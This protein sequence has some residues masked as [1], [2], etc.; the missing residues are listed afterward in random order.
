[1][2][3]HLEKAVA[4]YGENEILRGTSI[5]VDLG[6]LVSLIGP[7]GAG[8]TTIFRTVSGILRLKQGRK[9]FNG[10]DI[11]NFPAHEISKLGVAQVPEGRIVF[12]SLTV[13]QNILLG[14]YPVYRQLKKRGRTERLHSVFEIFPILS[15]RKSQLAGTLSGGEQQM[16]AI[17]RALIANPKLLLL[18]EPSLGLAPQ[19][20]EL[21][22]NVMSSLRKRGVTILLAEQNAVAA[23][24]L[25]DRAYL[26]EDGQVVLHGPSKELTRDDKVKRVYFGER[27]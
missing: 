20:V 17:G 8:K 27:L 15:E 12:P 3:L 16:L 25:T 7:N 19:V 24:E 23:L 6:E 10:S 22:F 5:S 14:C 18:D 4:G 2:L 9:L 11:T 26:I 13:L 1:M 21:I